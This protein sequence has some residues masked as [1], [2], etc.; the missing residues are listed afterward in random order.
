MIA[1]LQLCLKGPNDA[2]KMGRLFS[3]FQLLLPKINTVVWV[4][5]EMERRG[6]GYS[7]S[8]P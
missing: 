1:K 8:L 3:S 5:R 7:L 6:K 4:E 2:I